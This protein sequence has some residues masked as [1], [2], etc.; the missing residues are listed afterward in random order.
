MH[1]SPT[2]LAARCATRLNRWT[3]LVVFQ[4]LAVLEDA[5]KQLNLLL[6]LSQRLDQSV[7]PWQRSSSQQAP[8]TLSVERGQFD[9]NLGGSV[10]P[11]KCSKQDG[12]SKASNRLTRHPSSS[13]SAKH[14]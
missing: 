7:W 1:L 13:S 2:L 10:A 9:V 14:T 4:T 12:Y 11:P 5:L 3:R 6:I 8:K